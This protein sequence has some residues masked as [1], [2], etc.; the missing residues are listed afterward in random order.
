MYERRGELELIR[1]GR[2]QTTNH[3]NP[4]TAK[5]AC[6]CASQEAVV[7]EESFQTLKIVGVVA[8]DVENQPHAPTKSQTGTPI[9]AL[10][11]QRPP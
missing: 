5:I 1:D 7:V 6:P 11:F 9:L 2:T 10:H 4:N 3:T 8:L